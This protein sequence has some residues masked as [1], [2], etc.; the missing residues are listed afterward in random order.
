MKDFN[1][2]IVSP[3]VKIS[4]EYIESMIEYQISHVRKLDDGKIQVSELFFIE[5]V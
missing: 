2:E 1:L 4:D 3:N 5:F